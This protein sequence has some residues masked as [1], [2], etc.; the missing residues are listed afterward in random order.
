MRALTPCNRSLA[1]RLPSNRR[2]ALGS[3]S[4]RAIAAPFRRPAIHADQVTELAPRRRS[5]PLVEAS[6][7]HCARDI[8]LLYVDGAACDAPAPGVA[9]PPLHGVLAG[10]AVAA[11]EL[12]RVAAALARDL[13][14]EALGDGRLQDC[15][16]AR[17]PHCRRRGGSGGARRRPGSAFRRASAA[18]PGSRRAACRTA[19]APGRSR[20]RPRARPRP[21]P[22]PS[23]R[24]RSARDRRPPSACGSRRPAR[25]RCP[26]GTAAL[27]K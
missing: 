17:A 10:I 24:C 7:D 6:A 13:V 12:N 26:S 11:H 19:G 14:G 21:A 9:Q 8:D 23:S 5:A 3:Q 1:A 18:R 27:S 16:A 4:W 22:A 20:P 15:S 25:R 2:K